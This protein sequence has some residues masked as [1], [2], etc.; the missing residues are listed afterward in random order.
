MIWVIADQTETLD[1][2]AGVENW[3]STALQVTTAGYV[4]PL[5]SRQFGT[6]TD[7]RGSA[8]VAASDG[9]VVVVGTTG[10]TLGTWRAGAGAVAAGLPLLVYAR[11]LGHEEWALFR[12][13]LLAAVT[14]LPGTGNA[15][16]AKE[17]VVAGKRFLLSIGEPKSP[18]P[19]P[20]FSRETVPIS[21]IDDG[22]RKTQKEGTSRKQSRLAAAT[23]RAQERRRS[24]A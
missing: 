15:T 13:T 23:K 12:R 19:K 17:E 2:K 6:S 24:A 4:A 1:M 20:H 5:W 11:V 21:R 18:L 10:G 8:L 16:P 22:K 9:S 7:D 14:R 3:A